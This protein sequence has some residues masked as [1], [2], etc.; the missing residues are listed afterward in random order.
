MRPYRRIVQVRTEYSL[1]VIG[2]TNPSPYYEQIRRSK[3]RVYFFDPLILLFKDISSKP[4]VVP[5]RSKNKKKDYNNDNYCKSSSRSSSIACWCDISW[6][7]INWDR[8]WNYG[9]ITWSC[10]T[11]TWCITIHITSNIIGWTSIAR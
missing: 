8:I 7:W 2:R 9:L 3:K 6:S 11:S 1:K 4:R 5:H 10:I